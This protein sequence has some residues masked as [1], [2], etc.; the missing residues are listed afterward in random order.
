MTKRLRYY[1]RDRREREQVER[2]T[3]RRAVNKD[4]V[5]KTTER[6]QPNDNN[7]TTITNLTVQTSFCVLCRFV[8][9]VGCCCA[10][11]FVLFRTCS[12]ACR[13]A[14]ACSC[15]FAL[16]CACCLALARVFCVAPGFRSFRS[17]AQIILLSRARNLAL[18]RSGFLLPCALFRE[19]VV[20]LSSN[21]IRAQRSRKKTKSV[22]TDQS[23]IFNRLRILKLN[24]AR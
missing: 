12:C 13:F 8:S 11:L 4:D 16:A 17:C 6:R 21:G 2:Q 20:D 24:D 1:R 3:K 18:S 9:C 10:C 7:R 22:E 14:L 23:V 5:T 15:C 19:F